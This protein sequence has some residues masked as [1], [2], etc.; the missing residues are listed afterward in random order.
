MWRLAFTLSL[1]SFLLSA[2]EFPKTLYAF[3]GKTPK[4]DG[5]IS[6]GEWDDATQFFGVADW[7]PQFSP[8]KDPKDLSV[9]GAVKHDGKRLY[10]VFDVTDDV[11]YGIDT[12]RWLP[13]NNPKAHEL[14]QEGYP[15]FGDEM[16][17]LINAAN[18]W[19]GNEN[20]AGDGSSWQ[21]VCNVTKSRLGGVGNGG[22]LEGEPRKSPKAW[23]TYRKWIESGAQQCAVK[24]KPDGHGYILEWSVSFNPCL[25][26]EP[27]VFYSTALG[28]RAMGLNIALGDLDEKEKG[29]GNFGN[30]HHEDWWTGAKDVRTQ[31]RQW[32]TLWIMVKGKPE[33]PPSKLTPTKP[34]PK[35]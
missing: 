3:P 25:E 20:A 14:T 2:G 29:E 24:P 16:E 10:F 5:V 30:F 27:G 31:L 12:P 28:N 21:M 8:T 23:A 15:W 6:P 13:D 4:L 11:L 9:H 35:R 26:V 18:K 33:T 7:I 32:G 22:L 17:L 34:S 19:S 1:S